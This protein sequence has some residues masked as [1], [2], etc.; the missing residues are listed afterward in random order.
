MQIISSKLVFEL[1]A[2]CCK[3]S[4]AHQ[5]FRPM[6]SCLGY[7]CF[8]DDLPLWIYPKSDKLQGAIALP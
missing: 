1:I 2:F 4:Q 3:S 7:E 5:K 8:T 6:Q